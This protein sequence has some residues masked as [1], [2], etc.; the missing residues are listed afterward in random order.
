MRTFAGLRSA[1]GLLTVLPVGRA[2]LDHPAAVP[3]YPW[4]GWLFGGGGAAIAWAV[5]GRT[6]N[7][8]APFLAGV[9][10]VGA[11]TALSRLLH[12]DGLSDTADGLLGGDTPERRLEI[13]R[14]PRAGVFGVVAV[15]LVMLA[16]VGS[17]AVLAEARAWWVLAIAPVAGR[18]AASAGAMGV[19]PARNEGLGASAA[20]RGGLSAWLT[21]LAAVVVSLSVP[22][23]GRVVLAISAIVLAVLLPRALSRPVGGQTGDILG[24]SVLLTETSVLGLGA[25]AV[26][27]LGGG[28]GL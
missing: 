12:W 19:P 9:A 23:D 13:M 6:E 20:V 8:A 21:A 26:S 24:A 5:A 11:W 10:V 2:S 17:V 18:L 7:A 3:W 15:V 4:A 27:V 14:D 22:S 1:L 28:S 16:E 25:V